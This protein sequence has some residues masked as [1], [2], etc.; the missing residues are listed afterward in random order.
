MECKLHSYLHIFLA[1]H[2]RVQPGGSHSQPA[3]EALPA[4]LRP[5]GGMQ[6]AQLRPRA[7]VAAGFAEAAAH[8]RHMAQPAGKATASEVDVIGSILVHPV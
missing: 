7:G 6:H 2:E 5:E 8:Q 4:S 3:E 1:K